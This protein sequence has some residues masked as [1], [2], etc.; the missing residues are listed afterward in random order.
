ERDHPDSIVIELRRPYVAQQAVLVN[1]V[2]VAFG[3]RAVRFVDPGSP[4]E[5][6][7]VVGFRSDLR[8]V[9]SLV[10]S[11]LVQLATAMAE[12]RPRTSS[13]SATASWRRSFIAGFVDAIAARLTA[14]RHDAA[15][16]IIEH[17]DAS[18]T[19]VSAELVL[20]RR[21]ELVDD[22]FRRRHPW[23]RS[24]RVG[25]GSS[26][27]GRRSG[28]AAGEQADLQRR[29]VGGRRALPGA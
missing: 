6:V 5:R 8:L 1:E 25:G 10:T 15:V 16:E 28:E 3:C 14:D 20:R 21:E 18:R 27:H 29:R 13:A 23:V 9:E 2:A 26:A 19:T 4:F 12:A 11:L 17:V 7:S 22:E 24:A